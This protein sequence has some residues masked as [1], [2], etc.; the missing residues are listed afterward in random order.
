MDLVQY[1]NMMIEYKASDLYVTANSPLKM[2]IDGRMNSI[3]EENLTAD[4][5]RDMVYAVM[6]R[7]QVQ[8]YENTQECDF[9]VSIEG[10]PERFRINVFCQRSCLAAVVRYVPSKIP[11]IEELMLPK[12]LKDLVLARRGLVLVVGAT[13]SGKSTATAA[14]LEYRNLHKSGHILTIEDPIEF[15]YVN[16]RSIFNQREIGVDTNSY[17]SALRSAMRQNPDVVMVGEIRDRETLGAVI[18]LC[19][20]G[21]LVLTTMHASNAHQ[22]LE[23]VVN[24]IHSDEQTLMLMDLAL[25]LNAV[26]SQRLIRDV[27][28]KLC[29]AVELLVKTPHI[30]EI[31]LA[32]KFSD[33]QAAMATSGAQG[34]CTFDQSLYDLHKAGT[35]D[36]QQAL[37]N[38][39]SR[40][41]IESRI[42]F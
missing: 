34:M 19:N 8:R 21:H 10:S 42:H 28:G 6:S 33:L 35:I 41:D 18:Q 31:I 1:F 36:L 27:N 39:D 11:S 30:R 15:S 29:P 24:M 32:G 16:R 23:R 26:I 38:A 2:R 4:V 9:S 12:T 14:M 3:G 25:N 5:I 40:A 17:S 37:E 22:T 7:S 20:T 13:G